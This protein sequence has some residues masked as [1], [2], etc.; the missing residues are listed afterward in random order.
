VQNILRAA[1]GERVR[2]VRFGEHTTVAAPGARVNAGQAIP[3]LFG[4]ADGTLLKQR[5]ISVRRVNLRAT[6]SEPRLYNSLGSDY[7]GLP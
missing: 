6:Q 3:H 4:K 7:S 2:S 5:Q 1:S